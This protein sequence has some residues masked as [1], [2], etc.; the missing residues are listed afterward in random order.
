MAMKRVMLLAVL[1]SGCATV[2]T[3][4]F[5]EG[6]NSLIGQPVE[7]AFDRLGYPQ[8]QEVMAGNTVYYWTENSDCQFNVV[9]TPDAKVKKWSGIG[10]PSGCS[11]Y[12]SRLR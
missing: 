8:R 5:S 7:V 11:L 10:S 4:P 3:R 9:A 6:M 2:S 1:V 12:L